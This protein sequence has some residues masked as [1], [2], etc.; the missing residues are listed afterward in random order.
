MDNPFEI[1]PEKAANAVKQM[2]MLMN[3][4]Y[5]TVWKKY[6]HTIVKMNVEWKD[7][8]PLLIE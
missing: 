5:K 4:D 1:T 7:I 8:E 3:C 6:T 2:A